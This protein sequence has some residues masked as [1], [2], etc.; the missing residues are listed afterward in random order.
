MSDPHTDTDETATDSPEDATADAAPPAPARAADDALE[1]VPDW[2]DGYV[3]RVSDRLFHNYDL[4]KDYAADG[5]RFTLYGR[6]ELVNK[7]HFLHPA[8]SLAEHESTE[9]LF[10]RRVDRVDDRTLD[11]FVDLGERLADDWIDPDEEHFSTDFTFVAIAPSI[12][13]AVRERV[14]GYDGRTLLKYG[15]HGHYEINLAVVSPDTEDL[16]ASENADVA[17][18][19]RLWDPIETDESGLL[20]LLSRRLQL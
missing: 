16:V 8:L 20:G 9:H 10:V 5:E 3:D 14:A 15:Y 4:E 12:P 19:F 7:K 6:M 18:A 13:E 2:D 1:D 11:R 17:T